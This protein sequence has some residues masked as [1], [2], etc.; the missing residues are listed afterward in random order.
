[1][2][3]D[4]SVKQGNLLPGIT[5]I[6]RDSVGPAD[7]EG[8]AAVF[9]M[10]SV[11]NGATVVNDAAECAGAIAFLASGATLTAALHGLNNGEAVTLRS[12]G[13]L[14]PPF[15]SQKEYFVVN[16][17]VNTLQLALV[18]GG[19]PIITTN[20]GSGTHAL[21]SGRVSYQW[22]VGDTDVAGT[23][24]AEVKTTIDGKPLTYPNT[25]QFRVEVTSNLG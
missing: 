3:A 18:P 25:R 23:Y 13:A 7:L 10:R 9:I 12:T 11:L 17:T 20:S 5:V 24:V 4:F 2:A 6:V 22:Q 15:S 16:A 1:M 14:P 21:L 8:A 19:T